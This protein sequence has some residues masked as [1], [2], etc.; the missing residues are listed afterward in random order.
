MSEELDRAI[1]AAEEARQAHQEKV[2]FGEL[3]ADD[4]EEEIWAARALVAELI[5]DV[6]PT[7]D[8]N[9]RAWPGFNR[10]IYEIKRRAG[11]EGE[12]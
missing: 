12:G 3:E 2:M 10:A 11:L 4:M 9:P 7:L 1:L 8:M 5:K 6:R